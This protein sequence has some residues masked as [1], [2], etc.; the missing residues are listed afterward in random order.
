MCTLQFI[1]NIE[2]YLAAITVNRELLGEG[3]W[4]S[5]G[6]WGRKAVIREELTADSRDQNLGGQEGSHDVSPVAGDELLTEGSI[7]SLGAGISDQNR[8]G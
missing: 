4:H 6:R 8:L 1:K 7:I 2:S 3:C 5:G